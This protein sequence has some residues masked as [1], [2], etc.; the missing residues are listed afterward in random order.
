VATFALL[1]LSLAVAPHRLRAQGIAA[2]PTLDQV[3]DYALRFNPDVVI[4]HFQVDS[5]SGD[6]R[7][8]RAVPNPSFAVAP[9][10]PFQYSITQPVDIGPNRVYRTR[11]GREGV[12]AAGLDARN[13]RRQVI[14]SVRQAFLDLQLAE[15][16]RDIAFEQDT[17]MH[18]LLIADSLRVAEGDLAPRDLATTELQFAHAEA[19]LARAETSARAARVALQLL[20]GI[21]HPD[22]AFRVRGSLEFHEVG[23]LASMSVDSLRTAALATRPDVAAADA[24]IEQSQ[25]LHR[26]ASTLAVPIPG[27]AAVYQ[28]QPFTTGSHYALGISLSVPLLNSFA[29]ERERAS[30]GVQSAEENRRKIVAAADGELVSAVDALHAARTVAARYANGLLTKASTALDMQ[31]YA[32]DHGNASLLDLL[33]AIV[34]FGDTRTDYYTAVHDYWVAAYAID[35]A[36]GQDIIP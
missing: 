22:P 9:G 14:F 10:T 19:T 28:P 26:L 2:S 18:R 6:A 31:R 27:L 23:E 4:A 34:A 7:A 17:I 21:T 30:A 16:T 8:L 29:G 11:A 20:M 32:Y 24:R 13:V 33:T 35:R 3:V 36:V 1:F 25:S 12:T 15:A 5:A